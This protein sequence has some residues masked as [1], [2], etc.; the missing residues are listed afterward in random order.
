MAS[1]AALLA[2][3]LLLGLQDLDSAAATNLHLL[4]KDQPGGHCLD[5]SPAGYYLSSNVGTSSIDTKTWVITMDGG[6]ACTTESSCKQRAK[7]D[8]GSSTTWSS[9]DEYRACKKS[10]L[11]CT[12]CTTNPLFCNATQVRVPYCSGDGHR[13][14]RT[15][16]DAGSWGMYFQ[17]HSS[18]VNI[19]AE[20]K[21][22]HGLSDATHVV[23]TGNSAGGIGVFANVDWLQIALPNTVVKGAPI[24]GWFVPGA[25]PSDQPLHPDDPPSDW[26]HWSKNESG[27]TDANDYI[28]TLWR[29]ILDPACVAGETAKQANPFHCL[30]VH[31]S[32]KYI[33]APMYVIENQYD[34][35]QL[36][37]QQGLPKKGPYDATWR[38]YVAMYGAAMRAST[39]QVLT[40][41]HKRGDGLFHPSCLQHSVCEYVGGDCLHEE[42]IGGDTRGWVPIFSDWFWKLGKLSAKYTQVETCPASFNGLPCNPN[43]ECRVSGVSPSPSPPPT[44]RC[45]AQLAK[46]GCFASTGRH[47]DCL[48]CAGK[49]QSDLRHAECTPTLVQQLCAGGGPTPSPAPTP[50]PAN[51]SAAEKQYCSGLAGGGASK[52]DPCFACVVKFEKELMAAGCFSGTGSGQRHAFI[53]AFCK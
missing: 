23:L 32:Y 5:G 4:P 16:A 6:G 44:G 36:Y 8:K 18:F 22:Q 47:E 43:P 30:S 40:L 41:P 51:C 38:G 52:G 53:E 9:S 1:C 39:N 11:Y 37:T 21:L 10:P 14:N 13:G 12:N 27:D 31:V 50:P 35:E 26:A 45:S 46:D 48:S 25:L 3:A 2:A 7:S 42:N 49:H 33:K 15:T 20:L 24:A 19:V 29:P 34:T 17:G 28:A